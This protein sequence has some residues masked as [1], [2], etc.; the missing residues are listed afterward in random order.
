MSPRLR[1]M[2]FLALH[3]FRLSPAILLSSSFGTLRFPYRMS[4]NFSHRM[5]HLHPDKM[6]RLPTEILI[7]A[8]KEVIHGSD[9][10]DHYIS[11]IR[12]MLVCKLWRE[13]VIQDTTLWSKITVS[14]GESV[15]YALRSIDRSGESR[16]TVDLTWS[17]PNLTNANALLERLADRSHR[18]ASFKL[19]T[20][21]FPSLPMWTSPAINLHTLILQNKGNSR[22]LND[23][24]GRP[25][26]QLRSLVLAGFSSWPV[27]Y[28][29]DLHHLTLQIPPSH[30][31]V[32]SDAFL[33][34][35]L[36]SPQL[37]GL[38]IIGCGHISPLPPPSKVATLPHLALLVIYTSS[39]HDFLCHMSLPDTVEIRMINC[40]DAVSD[41]AKRASLS[42]LG[43]PSSALSTLAIDL[44]TDHSTVTFKAFMRGRPYP[45]LVVTEKP[46][47]SSKAAVIKTLENYGTLPVFASV[48][49]LTVSAYTSIKMPWKV[50]LSNFL[51]LQRL[52]LQTRNPDPE[53]FRTAFRREIGCYPVLY[54]SGSRQTK[55]IHLDWRAT[56]DRVRYYSAFEGI[57]SAPFRKKG[58]KIIAQM[59]PRRAAALVERGR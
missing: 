50:W 27:G 28:F 1:V 45:S 40:A 48:Q 24:I 7:M 9:P 21:S 54:P 36:A 42:H 41:L 16:L 3:P 38:C 53:A 32:S 17:S 4:R 26:P 44:K 39:V 58:G 47:F 51:A 25:L 29:R 18:L 14:G 20:C 33:D 31:T 55:L 52:T 30:G 35:L 5:E 57:S 56:S 46:F 2:G 6:H 15:P 11:L 8:F 22:P 59:K 19:V 23:F 43:D 34:L 13:M 49:M 37:R 10:G 12:F